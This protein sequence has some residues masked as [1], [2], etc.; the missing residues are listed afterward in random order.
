MDV[1]FHAFLFSSIDSAGK[2]ASRF[3]HFSL[4]EIL[5]GVL[6]GPTAGLDTTEEVKFLWSSTKIQF[7]FQQG[8]HADS[9][10]PS[11]GAVIT[12]DVTPDRFPIKA[13]L[14]WGGWFQ[15][16]FSTR[17]IN[18]Y[19]CEKNLRQSEIKNKLQI[20]EEPLSLEA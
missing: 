20:K 11:S 6:M 3:S 4:G 14:K 1:W 5:I 15:A 9:D 12:D 10:S 19:I 8:Q 7:G 18:I 2:S 16:M 13:V 17:R